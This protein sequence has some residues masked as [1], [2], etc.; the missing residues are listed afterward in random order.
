MDEVIEKL[1]TENGVD[2]FYTGGMGQFDEQF[3]NTVRKAKLKYN[4]ISIILIKP[5]FSNELNTNKEYY[6][7]R[8]DDV[9]VC[10]ESELVHPKAAI[11]KRNRWMV[12]ECDF[13]IGY[14]QRDYGG[15][16]DAIQ[17]VTVVDNAGN[18]STNS[19]AS[20]IDVT[21]PTID[22][23]RVSKDLV[24]VDVYA[25]EGIT[26]TCTAKRE[27]F[28]RMMRDSKLGKIDRI[29]V[30]SVSRFARNSLECIENIRLLK[31]YGT[32]VL[33]ENDGI[34][35]S[36]MNSEMISAPLHQGQSA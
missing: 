9:M 14:I 33:F 5:Y 24:L 17:Y 30:K 23:I 11:K 25:D 27:E 18:T 13:V 36:S 12:D 19:K 21:N 7:Y 35:T 6:N 1:I 16:Y 20:D 26:G 29:F 31:S 22:I 15:A 2:V 10:E 28:N 34:D 3:T 8:Y 4:H 32:T